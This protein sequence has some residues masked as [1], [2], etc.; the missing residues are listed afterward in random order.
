MK[1][2]IKPII[3]GENVLVPIDVMPVGKTKSFTN[4][5]IGHS[6]TGHHHVLEAVKGQEFD[7]FVKGED[8]FISSQFESSVVHKKTQEIHETVKVEPGVY[9]VNRKLEY[10]PFQKVRRAV[11]D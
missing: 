9:K 7:I 8:I 3:H 6:E 11:Y 1:K 2:N 4:Y 10:D 5:I